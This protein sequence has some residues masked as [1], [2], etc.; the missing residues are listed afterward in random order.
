V[1]QPLCSR[2]LAQTDVLSKDLGHIARPIRDGTHGPPQIR[3][4]NRAI[5]SEFHPRVQTQGGVLACETTDRVAHATI[6]SA[7]TALTVTKKLPYPALGRVATGDA[8]QR[9]E[10]QR[11][12]LRWQGV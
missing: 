9:H 6:K 4:G 3:W 12:G 5:L 2:S 10:N 1:S 7:D 11:H 8:S